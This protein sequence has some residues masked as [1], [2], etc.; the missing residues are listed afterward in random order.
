VIS[1][2][3]KLFRAKPAKDAMKSDRTAVSFLGNEKS[4]I[5]YTFNEHLMEDDYFDYPITKV[6]SPGI[7][8]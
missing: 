8:I 4:V 7:R 3:S 2:T 6:L 1:K 5:I